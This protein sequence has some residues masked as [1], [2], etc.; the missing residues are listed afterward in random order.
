[1]GYKGNYW[2][3][4][5]QMV[6]YQSMLCR[7]QH[8]GLKVVKILNLATLFPLDLGLPEPD[9]LQ[10]TLPISLTMPMH[11]YKPR[12]IIWVKEWNVQP[13]KP[14][15]REPLL[16]FHLPPPQLKWQR[17]LSGSST[18]RYSQLLLSGNASQT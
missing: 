5:L 9:W 14:H 2:L 1:M 10:K 8:I 13:L 18:A 11:P 17:L 3:T 16:L 4:N 6:K 12:D 15:W 7:N